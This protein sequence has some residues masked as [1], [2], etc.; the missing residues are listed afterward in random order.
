[1]SA[2]PADLL[3]E[4]GLDMRQPLYLTAMMAVHQK[5]NM[6]AHLMA[7]RRII[8]ALQVGDYAAVGES[9]RAMGF[10]P[11]MGQMCAM[12]GAATPGFTQIALKFHHTADE[13]A[14]AAS[15]RD[16]PAVLAAL[17]KT[18]A[19]CTT[20]HAEYVQKVVSDETWEQMAHKPSR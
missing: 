2:A 17:G 5:Q 16:E 18:L 7:V 15:K 19:V 12:M 10:S 11:K 1:V 6:R 4:H 8:A 14:A 13:V 20:C 3:A 9:A